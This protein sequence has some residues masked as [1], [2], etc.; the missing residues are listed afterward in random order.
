YSLSNII[1]QYLS[2][3]MDDV[4]VKKVR[5]GITIILV[6]FSKFIFV[7]TWA[8]FLGVFWETAVVLM[9]FAYIRRVA[10]GIHAKNSLRCSIFSTLF[11]VGSALIAKSFYFRKELIFIVLVVNLVLI[12]KFGPAET[13]KNPISCLEKRKRLKK[14]GIKRMIISAII[15]F[16]IPIM[17]IRMFILSG[18]TGAI[19][20]IL[21]INFKK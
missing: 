4:S 6:N 21:P 8:L 16:F 17:E 10:G 1:V 20:T 7:F 19:F 12:Y 5:L 14:E 13:K 18:L 15:I 9:A 11:L 2:N 3:Y